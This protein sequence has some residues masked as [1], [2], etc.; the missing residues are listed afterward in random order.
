MARQVLEGT[1]E[2]VARHA[3]TFIGKKVRVTVFDDEV[4]QKPNLKVLEIINKVSENQKNR[5]ETFGESSVDII[6]RG[7]SGEMFNDN[8]NE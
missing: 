5:E 8:S 6:R 1:W 4:L 3:K 7:R 2:E